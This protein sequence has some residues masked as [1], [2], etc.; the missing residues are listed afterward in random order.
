MNPKF[1]KL[2]DVKLHKCIECGAEL[3]FWKD[4]V[5]LTCPECGQVNF[6]PNLGNTCLVWCKQAAECL[7]RDDINEWLK[8]HENGNAS[9]SVAAMA[10]S[11]CHHLS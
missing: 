11:G 3:E 4:D 2:E 8:M 7:G 1:F 9:P 10:V 6:N 5:R